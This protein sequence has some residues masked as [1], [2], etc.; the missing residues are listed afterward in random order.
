MPPGAPWGRG[1][2]RSSFRFS[3]STHDPVL[4]GEGGGGCHWELLVP[5]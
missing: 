4:L 1:W 3:S 5:T 2:P